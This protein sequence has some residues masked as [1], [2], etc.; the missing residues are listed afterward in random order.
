LQTLGLCTIEGSSFHT[1]CTRSSQS[2]LFSS[3]N[4]FSY[5]RLSLNIS[6]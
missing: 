3:R 6:F 2:V 4:V 5:T 1:S